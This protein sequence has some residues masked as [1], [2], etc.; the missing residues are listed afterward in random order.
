MYLFNFVKFNS[1]CRM[2]PE[3]RELE[4]RAQKKF[5]TERDLPKKLRITHG[6][7]SK[8]LSVQPIRICKA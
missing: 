1:N 7:L 2:R 4:Q 5:T 3:R 6:S 8:Y